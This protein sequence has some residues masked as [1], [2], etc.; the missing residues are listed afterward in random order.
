MLYRLLALLIVCFLFVS[1]S[2]IKADQEQLNKLIEQAIENYPQL[3]ASRLSEDESYHQ[4]RSA[5]ALPDPMISVGVL[6]LPVSSLSLSETPM[7]GV[8][9]GISQRLPW[10]G[11]LSDKQEIAR[12][13]YEISKTDS[14]YIENKIVKE[15]SAAYFTFSY[16]SE[17]RDI[18]VENLDLL[19]VTLKIIETKYENGN[20][21]AQSL[22][23]AKSMISRMDIKLLNIDQQIESSILR[24]NFLTGDSLEIK[25]LSPY[26]PENNQS[27]TETYSI[28]GN[29]LFQKS[30]LD[31]ERSLLKRKLTKKS[32]YP[33]FNL[34]VD[35]RFRKE[36]TGD[37]VHGEDYLSFK[38][39][40]NLPITF[41]SK[42]KDDVKSAYFK[43]EAS[44][45]QAIYIKK[46]LTTDIQDKYLA[47][48]TN[49]AS[50]EKYKQ[51]ILPE[52]EASFKSAKVAYEVDK[53]D[54]DALLASY[55]DFLN[56]KVEKLSL[57]LQSNLIKSEIDEL[58]GKSFEREN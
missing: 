57:L 18:Y 5:G 13:G 15:V 17:V 52:T 37:P 28:T 36:V 12:L 50:I 3:K 1:V 44:K 46:K 4:S 25:S 20:A 14:R 56:A 39:G 27:I 54:F 34:G 33:D 29:P 49:R 48:K 7:S 31:I 22:F 9:I 26:L 35:Y 47:L 8:Q 24:L 16:W 58:T 32:Y 42:K 45:E 38:I 2:E 51:S 30:G 40:F 53:I 11:K 10:F 23:H 19:K 41:F 55:N 43:S 21:T 6:N